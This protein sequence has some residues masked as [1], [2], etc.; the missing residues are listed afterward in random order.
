MGKLKKEKQKRDP[1]KSKNQKYLSLRNQKEKQEG[2][3]KTFRPLFAEEKQA[4]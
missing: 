3:G 2:G 4:N 1:Q